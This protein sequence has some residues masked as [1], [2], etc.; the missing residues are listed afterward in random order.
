MGPKGKRN[1]RGVLLS[2]LHC[3]R[4]TP[5]TPRTPLGPARGFFFGQSFIACA[6]GL[7]HRPK[8]GETTLQTARLGSSSSLSPPAAGGATERPQNLVSAASLCWNFMT[9]RPLILV[10]GRKQTKR[11]LEP[12]GLACP[13]AAVLAKHALPPTAPPPAHLQFD[14]A[15]R[16][17]W[18]LTGQIVRGA[19]PRPCMGS[20]TEQALGG[21]ELELQPQSTGDTTSHT[22][23]REG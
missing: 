23:D 7:F 6:G 5:G 13:A 12:R 1:R 8:R 4:Q 16:C 3:L 19:P 2:L 20:Q 10:E 9:G 17:R 11:N 18:E 22:G 21:S 14:P 15:G